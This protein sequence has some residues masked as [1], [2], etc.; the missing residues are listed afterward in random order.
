V[1]IDD[2]NAF[3]ER[4]HLRLLEDIDAPMLFATAT[5]NEL[6]SF[7]MRVGAFNNV[8]RMRKMP[9]NVLPTK[10]HK[11]EGVWGEPPPEQLSHADELIRDHLGRGRASSSSAAR[12]ATCRA[13]RSGSKKPTTSTC[14]NCAATWPTRANSPS[15]IAQRREGERHRHARRDDDRVSRPRARDSRRDEP[16]RQR[17]RHSG[18]RP[19]RDHRFRCVRRSE[20]E[21]LIGRVG[22]RERPSDAVLVTG[23]T[24]EK[25]PSRAAAAAGR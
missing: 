8:V 5:P 18:R 3:D 2:V 12:A 24:F 4:E 17:H 7:L 9:F 23:T 22:R 20:T 16:D 11:I 1:F 14:S 13:S 10:V 21:Q 6:R 15:A 25:N 19:D